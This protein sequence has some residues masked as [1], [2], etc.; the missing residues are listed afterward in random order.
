MSDT[1]QAIDNI[2]NSINQDYL[3]VVYGVNR[4]LNGLSGGGL[5]YLGN[6]M[7]FDSQMSD[8]LS[9]LPKSERLKREKL[10]DLVE[11]GGTALLGN[12]LLRLA[13]LVG[14]EVVRWNGRR[15]LL[16]QLK[17]GH[18]FKDV[19]FG[20]VSPAKLEEL[21][22]IRKE[23]EQPQINSGKVT[24]PADRVE[25]IYERRV[26]GDRYKP[27][28]ATDTIYKALFGKGS[29]IYPDKKHDT[30]QHF[31]DLSSKP[32]NKAIV[33]KIKGG[34]NIFVKTGFKK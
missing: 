5:D 34:D 3:D 11:A 13:P 33:G 8:Y 30:L 21:N 32:S 7:G 20:K 29:K 15:G 18:N 28:D 23:L 6:K 2:M 12:K 22:K 27:E 16:N 24:I 31:I 9:M 1:K 19:N 26:L 17:R 25:H 14:D 10:G 4:G